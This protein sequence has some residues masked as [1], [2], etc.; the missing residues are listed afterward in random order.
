MKQRGN[1]ADEFPDRKADW[2]LRNKKAMNE[3][4]PEKLIYVPIP[5]FTKFEM[6]NAVASDDIEKQTY[7]PLFVSLYFED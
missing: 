1:W 6:E 7:I 3:T 5:T 2:F 4:N